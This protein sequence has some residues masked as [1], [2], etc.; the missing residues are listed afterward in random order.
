MRL[1][2]RMR[3]GRRRANIILWNMITIFATMFCEILPDFLSFCGD[4]VFVSDV[5]KMIFI[6]ELLR[7]TPKLIFVSQKK[8]IEKWTDW[9]AHFLL[10]RRRF[11]FACF[12]M[13]EAHLPFYDL[14]ISSL[15]NTQLHHEKTL[16]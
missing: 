16:L 14:H 1:V 7:P 4:L 10:P 15:D 8:G 6:L 5:I 9:L 2:M 12:M 13:L 11:V 3:G